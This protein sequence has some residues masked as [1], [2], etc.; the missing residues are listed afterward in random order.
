[1]ISKHIKDLARC[2]VHSR[3]VIVILQGKNGAEIL[4]GK[5]HLTQVSE[6]VPSLLSSRGGGGSVQK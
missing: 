4:E 6:P 1:M 2:L 5:C 3:T